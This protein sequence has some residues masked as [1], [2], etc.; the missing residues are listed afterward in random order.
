CL[1]FPGGL[2]T[3]ST[4]RRVETRAVAC[5][6]EDIELVRLLAVLAKAS[7][8]YQETNRRTQEACSAFQNALL[9][10][11]RDTGMAFVLEVRSDGLCTTTGRV[12]ADPLRD[13]LRATL[14]RALLGAIRIEGTVGAKELARFLARLRSTTVGKIRKDATFQ[15]L[16][17]EPFAGLQLREL[18][19]FGGYGAA[20]SGPR[21]APGG[22]A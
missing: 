12:R 2:E 1:P 11:T 20:E 17:P 5:G 7:F 8:T 4:P 13:W 18:R 14:Q 16:W 10:R 3:L 19:F 6:P 21:G 22:P 9:A 15:S